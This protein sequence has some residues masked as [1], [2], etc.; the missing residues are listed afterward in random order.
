MRCGPD[1]T[2]WVVIDPTPRSE[3]A[4]LLFQTSLRDLELQL[5]GGLS[6][7]QNPTLFSDEQEAKYEAYGRLTV[8]RA[9]QV[10]RD[11]P[12]AGID[13]VEVC[14][15]DGTIVFERDLGEGPAATP[16]ESP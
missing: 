10:R 15:A 14:G 2:F 8:M 5:R 4:D 12:D 9:A 13:R 3:M 11:H 16:G 6:M 7:D 1:D